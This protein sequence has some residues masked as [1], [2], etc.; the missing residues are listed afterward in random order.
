MILIHWPSYM[1]ILIQSLT[2][3]H[4]LVSEIKFPLFLIYSLVYAIN[5]R[6]SEWSTKR[7]GRHHTYRLQVNPNRSEI[8]WKFWVPWVL[9]RKLNL[10]CYY[11]SVIFSRNIWLS[12][13]QAHSLHAQKWSLWTG[14]NICC[15]YGL[16]E[17]CRKCPFTFLVE[18]T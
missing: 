17:G 10:I 6:L 1:K 12:E 14:Y 4:I 15:N 16:C 2:V 11:S 5:S 8:A 13:D 3:L 18:C 7:W 9:K